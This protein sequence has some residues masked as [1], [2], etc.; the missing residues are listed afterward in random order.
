VLLLIYCK[1][2]VYGYFKARGPIQQQGKSR[3]SLAKLSE[4]RSFHEPEVRCITMGN[5]EKKYEFG[6]KESITK[7]LKPGIRSCNRWRGL[8]QRLPALRNRRYANT[9]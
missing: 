8:P 9:S 3:P 4:I 5:E 7:T 1:L 6:N 2:A